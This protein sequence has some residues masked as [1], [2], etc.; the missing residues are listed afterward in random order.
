MNTRT[1]ALPEELLSDLKTIAGAFRLLFCLGLGII[2]LFFIFWWDARCSRPF[3]ETG[4]T[5]IIQTI[6]LALSTGIFFLE[7]RRRPDMGNA[8]ILAG[9]FTGCM[10]I[11][12]QDYFLDMLS[13]G[14]WKWPA[15]L[16][17]L[18]CL[19]PACRRFRD[20]LSGL[21]R[22]IRWRYFP[23]LLT[24]VVIVLAYSRLF[25]TGV[26]WKHLLPDEGWRTAKNAVEESSELLGYGLILGSALLLRLE[27]RA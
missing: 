24:G 2:V 11:R 7:A 23:L 26:L 19:I 27:K 16:L 5:E 25:G 14:C 9:G 22:L 10:L 17:A 15:L 20:T 12:E 3:T 8:L 21:A 1:S 18:A 6:L 4:P 13:H